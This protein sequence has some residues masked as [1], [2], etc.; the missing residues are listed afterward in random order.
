M[1]LIK[2]PECGKQISSRAI[3]CP[4]CGC[5]ISGSNAISKPTTAQVRVVCKTNT[6]KV[7][8]KPVSHGN[9]VDITVN[10][11]KN[12]TISAWGGAVGVF[13]SSINATVLAGHK[14]DLD[15]HMTLVGRMLYLKEV[16][17]FV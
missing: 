3:S 12:I 17:S 15:I 9:I 2:C 16:S 14:Y 11:S 4:S 5:P 10:N 8:G 1:A 6:M 7:D 13:G